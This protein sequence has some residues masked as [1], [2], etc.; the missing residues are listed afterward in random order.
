MQSRLD[1]AVAHLDAAKMVILRDVA[2]THE[3]VENGGSVDLDMRI[4]NR[5]THSYVV[6]LA[7]DAINGLYSVSG[8]GGID[9]DNRIGRAWRDIN[10]ISHHIS[11]NW[12]AGSSRFGKHLLGL[13]PDG[14]F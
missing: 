4:R 14:Q 5:M 12:D 3:R 13:E 7:L 9:T 2:E 8:I 6:K 10:A 11:L 1:E